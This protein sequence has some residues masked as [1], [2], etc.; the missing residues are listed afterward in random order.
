MIQA[1]SVVPMEYN[2]QKSNSKGHEQ[3][4]FYCLEANITICAQNGV[5]EEIA[6]KVTDSWTKGT[7]Q[8]YHQMSE[9]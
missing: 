4:P 8:N 7:K 2:K 6:R 5:R 9:Q 3:H 1:I